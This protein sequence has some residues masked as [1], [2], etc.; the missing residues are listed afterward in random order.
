MVDY[1]CNDDKGEAI[2]FEYELKRSDVDRL[3]A[4]FIQR[5]IHI[6][7]QALE[8]SHLGVQDI[9]KLIYVGDPAMVVL[10]RQHIEDPHEGLGLRLDF[11]VDPRTV[12]VRGAA[13]FAGTQML[14][15]PPEPLL[16]DQRQVVEPSAT[17][18]IHSIGV[19]LPD[20][21]VSF[22]IEKGAT[23]PSRVRKEWRI[24]APIH[25][26]VSEET[27]HLPVVEG[28][29]IRAD[30]NRLI[31]YLEIKSEEIQRDIPAGT[32]VEITIQIDESRIVTCSAYI[33]L[34]D[35]EFE[36]VL[37]LEHA[38]PDIHRLEQD[39]EQ[40]KIR[41][42][43]A[44]ARA[45]A[46]GN[47]EAQ[48]ILAQR[49]DGQRM[50]Q[51]VETSLAVAHSDLDAR[52]KAQNRLLDL[53]IAIDEVES[54]L[55][56]EKSASEA[57]SAQDV[58]VVN[59][60]E[61]SEPEPDVKDQ[62]ESEPE[63]VL[64][65]Q[66]VNEPE[67]I[68]NP[69][70]INYGIHLGGDYCVMARL[71]SGE[72]E[73]LNTPDGAVLMP[74]AV[75]LD[76]SNQLQVGKPAALQ[77]DKDTDNTAAGFITRLGSADPYYFKRDGR[78]LSA[79]E[80]LVEEFK[81][82]L[83]N[84]H[85]QTGEEVLAAVVSVPAGFEPIQN[86]AVERA[87]RQAGLRQ[88]RLINDLT[89][90][91]YAHAF[92]SQLESGTWLVFNFAPYSVE[93]AVIRKDGP[94]MQ[95]LSHLSDQQVGDKLIT[96][97]IVDTFLA[98]AA[99]RDYP[100]T[101][102]KRSNPRWRKAFAKLDAAAETARIQL[103]TQTSY[104]ISFDIL[105]A[106]DNGDLVPFE[107]DLKDSQVTQI[108]VPILKRCVALSLHAL[109]QANITSQAINWAIPIGEA[110]LSPTVDEYL[111]DPQSGLGMPLNF[112]VD[113]LTVAA[114]GAAV[115]A[116]R[117]LLELEPE[118]VAIEPE[119][120]P[121][122]AVEALPPLEPEPLVA[123]E[124]EPLP[125]PAV[126]AMPALEIEPVVAEPEPLPAPT[127]EAMPVPEAEPV[128]AETEPLPATAVEA[129]PALEPEPV[130]AEPEPLPAPAV[131]A[132]PVLE[133]EPVVAEPETLTTPVVEAMPVPETE[134][135][136]AES[137]M[138]PAP[139]VEAMPA[140]E[141]EPVVAEPETLTTPVVE[142]MPALEAEPVAAEPETL[143]TPAVEAMPPLEP[144]PLVAVEP[145]TLPA[146]AM[147][148]A[149]SF[150]AQPIA[151]EPE[152]LPA[153][154][155]EALPS[156]EAQPVAA[157]PEPLPATAVE[158]APSFEPEPVAAEPEPL[159]ATAVEA[160]PSFEP[161]PVAAEPEMLQAITP[162]PPE[163]AMPAL[164]PEPLVV[165]PEPEPLPAV[166]VTPAAEALPPSALANLKEL[167]SRLLNA[168]TSLSHVIEAGLFLEDEAFEERF[169]QML[170][171]INQALADLANRSK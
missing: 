1:L 33:A 20:N 72:V 122:P 54:T 86:E 110:T 7:R 146:T 126:E 147:E 18:L 37:K 75:W 13:I 124:P 137:E 163:E 106:D 135:V 104:P 14:E 136:T 70:M 134:P 85:Q 67:P 71:S 24:P 95:V 99:G 78:S 115:F 130:A 2:P 101:E 38:V 49:V 168:R 80:L 82:L 61:M 93:T 127:V 17:P 142:A 50:L 32:L 143:P 52:D 116:G 15:I 6:C 40:E 76:R 141:P 23:L 5:T 117:Q 153:T 103:T 28:E 133:P 140:L 161:E 158:A 120:L 79:E 74:T 60:Q 21:E 160:M 125:A 64:K 87:A 56:E 102:F 92:F 89:A 154:A 51:I 59:D 81:G 8:Q 43:E 34:L 108:S 107:Y 164:E 157:E 44:H 46:M 16:T 112:N 151:A 139:A 128:A 45:Q 68:T 165:T 138:Q 132:M 35:Q 22:F 53:K 31:G 131:E 159:P 169:E 91:V 149:P 4:P 83:A 19:A 48:S 25:R 114:Q 148:A 69:P 96:Q 42:Q 47:V 94:A 57:V 55:E 109:A 170:A 167:K 144:E 36:I 105:C 29:N 123:A 10:D 111:S 162:A 145:E 121:A 98:P 12:V 9:E 65:D 152:T 113:P 84:A 26:G 63:P 77:L 88:V 166:P 58:E 156:F 39:L 150:E 119:P 171:E 73:V 27:I 3:A 90:A 62:E 66:E 129:M 155:V 97:A 11:S 118:P 41:L 100:L 30:R